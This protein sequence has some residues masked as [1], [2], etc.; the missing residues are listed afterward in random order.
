MSS[1][2]C[3]SANPDVYC[4]ITSCFLTFSVVKCCESLVSWGHAALAEALSL[5][6]EDEKKNEPELNSSGVVSVW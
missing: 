1:E 6:T 3:S 5:H 2:V 4:N